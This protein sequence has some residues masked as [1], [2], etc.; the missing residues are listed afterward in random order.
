MEIHARVGLPSPSYW[1]CFPLAPETG[2]APLWPPGIQDL[3]CFT[4]VATARQPEPRL[5]FSGHRRHSPD[6]PWFPCSVEPS[7]WS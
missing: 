3:G 7:F 5:L 6:S 1:H 2:A 4:L